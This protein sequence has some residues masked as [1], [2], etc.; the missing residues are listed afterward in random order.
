[1]DFLKNKDKISNDDY[2]IFGKPWQIS[3]FI[4]IDDIVR[5]G[6]SQSFV[7]ANQD[8]S[9]LRFYGNLDIETLGGAGFASQRTK[10]TTK[11]YDLSSYKGLLITTK[12]GD[13]KIYQINLKDVLPPPPDDDGKVQSTIEYSYLFRGTK[14]QTTKFVNFKDFKPYYRGRPCSDEDSNNKSLNLTNI[15]TIGFMCAS[16]FGK[17]FGDFTITFDSIIATRNTNQ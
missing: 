12:L 4:A 2:Y 3:D 5:G 6:K 17:Q 14:E 10:S 16:L 1:M 9:E 11:T 7:E 13:S 8:K 15:R